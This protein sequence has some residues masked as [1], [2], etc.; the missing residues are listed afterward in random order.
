M[1][2]YFL[3]LETLPRKVK[4]SRSAN[5]RGTIGSRSRSRSHNRSIH[6]ATRNAVRYYASCRGC[7]Y[8]IVHPQFHPRTREPLR[9]LA[10]AR[11]LAGAVESSRTAHG[12]T[13]P[14]ILRRRGGIWTLTADEK[15]QP[16]HAL[17]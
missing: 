16:R 17:R 12:V 15:E 8:L 13:R 3:F 7:H 1:V 14:A 10:G 4:I 6:A 11:G 9:P 5:V 2:R